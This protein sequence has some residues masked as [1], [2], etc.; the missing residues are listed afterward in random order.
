MQCLVV[1]RAD[2]LP[3]G[4]AGGVDEVKGTILTEF[5]GVDV[6]GP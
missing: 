4:L 5:N 2:G 6:E 1:T 3:S